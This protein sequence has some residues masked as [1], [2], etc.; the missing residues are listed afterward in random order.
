[1]VEFFYHLFYE[2][3]IFF[4]HHVYPNIYRCV[5]EDGSVDI[6]YGLWT[7]RKFGFLKYFL[8][9]DLWIIKHV[10]KQYDI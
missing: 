2:C 9:A 6:E 8:K 4:V 10:F 3:I 5:S 1:M 7:L